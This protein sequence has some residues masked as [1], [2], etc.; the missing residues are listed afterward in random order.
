M[1]MFLIPWF[2][3]FIWL[4]YHS[5]WGFALP[6]IR[7]QGYEI[8]IPRQKGSSPSLLR[9]LQN[10]SKA[11]CVLYEIRDCTIIMLL[12]FVVGFTNPSRTYK[13]SVIM[14]Y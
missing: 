2:S 14:R 7:V 11:H 1:D 10:Y 12:L 6:Y 9:T 8:K 13:L 4:L 3:H 5:Q